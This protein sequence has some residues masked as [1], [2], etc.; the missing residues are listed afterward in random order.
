MADTG[1]GKG[2]Q[3]LG[4]D[5]RKP[6]HGSCSRLVGCSMGE[7]KSSSNLG[8]VGRKMEAFKELE[9]VDKSM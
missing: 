1:G 7:L 6:V 8:V 4:R 9:S 5:R 2:Y 3:Q